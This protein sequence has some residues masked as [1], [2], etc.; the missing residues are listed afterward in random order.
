[1]IPRQMQSSRAVL[2][3]LAARLQAQAIIPVQ[4]SRSSLQNLISKQA[5]LCT[6]LPRRRG[7]DI[8]SL[9]QKQPLLGKRPRTADTLLHMFGQIEIAGSGEKEQEEKEQEE[10]E[11]AGEARLRSSRAI[12]RYD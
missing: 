6:E 3:V 5:S 7:G 1:M 11:Q 10:K 2:S 4:I 9:P 12:K 8:P